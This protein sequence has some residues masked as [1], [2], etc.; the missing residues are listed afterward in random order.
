MGI[1]EDKTYGEYTFEVELTEK[2][3]A[4]VVAETEEEAKEMFLEI[5]ASNPAQSCKDVEYGTVELVGFEEDA[6][7]YD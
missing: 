5:V 4:T 3:Y 1:M 2:H 7:Y 6:N